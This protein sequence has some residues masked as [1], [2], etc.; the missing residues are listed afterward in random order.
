MRGLP[1]AVRSLIWYFAGTVFYVIFLMLIEG[2][3]DPDLFML[4]FFVMPFVIF[5]A[6]FVPLVG[7]WVETKSRR[8]A[9]RLEPL[10]FALGFLV[11]FISSYIIFSAII[12]S[13]V[14]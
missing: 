7:W 6:M 8:V 9:R 13:L 12:H 3:F 14:P 10:W 4:L 5:V 1:Y 11:V 2:E